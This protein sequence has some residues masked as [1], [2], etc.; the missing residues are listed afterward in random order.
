MCFTK[1]N[2]GNSISNK[3]NALL[4]IMSKPNLSS[5]HTQNLEVPSIAIGGLGA[6]KEFGFLYRSILNDGQDWGVPPKDRYIPLPKRGMGEHQ[7]SL[8]R[9]E[10]RILNISQALGKKALIV[11]HSLG[12]LFATEAT[13]DHPEAVEDVVVAAGAHVGKR[14]ET[15][16]SLAVRGGLT[17]PGTHFIENPQDAK[18]L[19]YNSE[20]MNRHRERIE[21]LWPEG[22]GLH[23]ISTFYDDMLPFMHGSKLKLPEGQQVEASV[24]AHPLPCMIDILRALTG[25]PNIR[26]IKSRRPALHVDIVRHPAF[27]S[28][29]RQL[30]AGKNPHNDAQNP[31]EYSKDAAV[32]T[33]PLA[34]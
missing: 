34:A 25:N 20:F 23:S 8:K 3:S 14:Y 24:I 19:H 2:L 15:F 22:V 17:M 6:G 29:I 18:D 9:V 1:P 31:D 11:G 28:Y 13:L 12:A 10:D 26:H 30:Q 4:K 7:E 27:I 33:L 16:T 21:S 32:I 5:A